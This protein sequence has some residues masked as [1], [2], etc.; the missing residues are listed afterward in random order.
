LYLEQVQVGSPKMIGILPIFLCNRMNFVSSVT[1]SFPL[2]HQGAQ[3]EPKVY[4]KMWKQT[5]HT[6]LFLGI[7]RFFVQSTHISA[8]CQLHILFANFYENNRQALG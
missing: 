2:E 1:N 3:T 5:F 7:G 6:L 8:Y 4:L